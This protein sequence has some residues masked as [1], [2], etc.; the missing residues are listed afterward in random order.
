MTRHFTA[1]AAALVALA[2]PIAACDIDVQK[3][4]VDGKAKVDITSPVGNVSVRTNVETPDTGLAVY[5]GARPLRDEDEPES[6]D[7]SVG[8]SMFGVKVLAAKFES[9]DETDKIID[10]YRNE[11]KAYGD[12]TECRGDI[13]FRG[14]REARR[15]VCREK[16]FERDLQLLAGPEDR[17]HIVSV[18]PRG[19]GTEFALVYVQTR[20]RS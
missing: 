6:A 3:E 2:L 17:Q 11:L 19:D 15:P 5:P 18:K 8:N 14:R 9:S 13:D 10:F 7:V 4:E 12:V 1:T 16:P 20:G